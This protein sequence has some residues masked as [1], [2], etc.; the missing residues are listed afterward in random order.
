MSHSTVISTSILA[1]HLTDP[2]WAVVD[3]RFDLNDTERG[4]EEY[5]KSHIPGAVYAHLDQDLSGR[6]IPG[7]TGRHPLPSVEQM[8]RTFSRWGINEDVQVVAYDDAGGAIA[9]RLWW[10][11]GYVGH[12]AVAVLDGGWPAWQA[13]KLPL[14]NSKETRERRRFVP[15]VRPE[16]AVDAAQVD[17]IR[18]D[19]SWRLLDA[20]DAERYRGEVEPIDPVAGHIPGAVSTPYKENLG[21]ASKLKSPSELRTR[22]ASAVGDAERVVAYCG[23]GVTACH[24]LLAM[25]YAGIDGARL[26]PG[27]WSDWITDPAREVAKGAGA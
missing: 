18:M 11:L 19:S 7:R 27:S 1:R 15:H 20:R 9:A 2:E 10:M 21:E 22:F 25:R 4:R 26:Y 5:L 17:A 14:N 3:C 23:S 6:V 16:W 13:E 8:V 12:D 24:N